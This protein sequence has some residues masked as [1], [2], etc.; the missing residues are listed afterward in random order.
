MPKITIATANTCYGRLARAADGLAPFAEANVDILTLQELRDP[1][2]DAFANQLDRYNF[3]LVHAAGTAGLAMVINKK[4]ALLHDPESVHHEVLRNM[5]PWERRL[6]DGQSR[7][8]GQFPERGLIA[9]RF[10]LDESA[11]TVATTHPFPPTRTR[12]RNNQVR[13]IG[14][15]LTDPRYDEN[16]V[17]TGDWNHWP[18]AQPGDIRMRQETGLSV[19]DIGAQQTWSFRNMGKMQYVARGVSML[20]YPTPRNIRSLGDRYLDKFGGQ[21][22]AVLYRG[23]GIKPLKTEVVPIQSDHRGLI[24]TFEVSPD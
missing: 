6:Y 15:H 1:E 22:D 5:R 7:L 11:V 13:L 10:L 19:A 3:A 17:V 18:A 2:A 9:A 8:V 24:S 12:S 4:S 21:L 14:Q 16:L 23:P 20:R